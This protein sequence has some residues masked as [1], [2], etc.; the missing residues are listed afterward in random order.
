MRVTNDAPL[1]LDELAERAGVSPR[2]VRFY[3]QRGLLPPP[4]FRGK[5][6]SYSHDHLV[7]LR[8]IQRLKDRFLPLHEIQRELDARSPEELERL[9]DGRDERPDVVPERPSPQP[10]APPIRVGRSYERWEL[11]DGLELH[12]ASDASDEARRL[13]RLIRSQ[14]PDPRGRKEST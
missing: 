8:A 14:A 9:A 1:K 5:D 2:T 13:A 10:P 12:L 7:R 4:V 3:V 11:A 6:S